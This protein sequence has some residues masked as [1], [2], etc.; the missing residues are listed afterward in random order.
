VI[1]SRN[2]APTSLSCRFSACAAVA[3]RFGAAV[4]ASSNE[5][6]GFEELGEKTELAIKTLQKFMDQIQGGMGQLEAGC[7]ACL[8]A[9]IKG[10]V[11]AAQ[12]KM[13]QKV[14]DDMDFGDVETAAQY[15]SDL[16]SAIDGVEST[17]ALMES[18]K[19]LESGNIGGALSSVTRI[20]GM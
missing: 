12:G 19:A 7:N 13:L 1:A 15:I 11:K 2:R 18:A 8:P 6:L 20:C 5:D 14:I 16:K 4:W 17:M 9:A 3:P 10:E